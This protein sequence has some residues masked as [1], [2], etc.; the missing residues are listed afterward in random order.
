MIKGVRAH[1]TTSNEQGSTQYLR[2]NMMDAIIDCDLF[3]RTL[4]P[5]AT[6]SN[7]LQP[8]LTEVTVACQP[9]LNPRCA[10]PIVNGSTAHCLI[11]KQ[12]QFIVRHRLMLQELGPRRVPAVF[13]DGVEV[14]PDA[15]GKHFVV[16]SE[17]R[18]Y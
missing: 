12:T 15:E 13:K 6:E 1:D 10:S 8:L 16:P 7:D 9:E 3:K 4:S 18:S 2:S 11:I 14:F 17:V 5:H